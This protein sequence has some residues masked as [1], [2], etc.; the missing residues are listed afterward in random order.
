MAFYT[1]VHIVPWSVRPWSILEVFCCQEFLGIAV[2]RTSC[3]CVKHQGHWDSCRAHTFFFSHFAKFAF[4]LRNCSLA[5]VMK[6]ITV[7]LGWLMIDAVLCWQKCTS[8]QILVLPAKLLLAVSM[9]M[10]YVFQFWYIRVIVFLFKAIM[11]FFDVILEC[12]IQ[13]L[14]LKL[15]QPTFKL[16]NIVIYCCFLKTSEYIT[17]IN[18]Q[19]QFLLL[20][21]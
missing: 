4:Q 15:V 2:A 10:A 9:L 14:S 16:N 11:Q 21:C 20:I 1:R 12:F 7:F 19:R 13:Q 3:Q 17:I 18:L 5:F 8:K 6:T